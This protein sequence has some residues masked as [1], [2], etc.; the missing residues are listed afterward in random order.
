MPGRPLHGRTF[1]A[2][3]FKRPA[4]FASVRRRRRETWSAVPCAA[5]KQQNHAG[6]GT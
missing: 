4:A 3:R 2:L 1:F 6:A 5:E